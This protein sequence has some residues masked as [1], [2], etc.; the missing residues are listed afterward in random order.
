MLTGGLDGLYRA[1]LATPHEPIIRAEVWRGTD[2]IVDDLPIGNGEVTATL[3]S[4]VSRIAS[5]VTYEPFYDE[6]SPFT[7]TLRCFRGI[8]LGD[9]TPLEWPV[10]VGRL[11]D[12]QLDADGLVTFNA[13]DNAGAVLEN[14]FT[15]PEN[16]TVGAGVRDE[17]QRII[18][19]RF[20]GALFGPS[21]EYFQRVPALTWEHDPGQA[22][23]EMATA[24][25]SYWYALA[26][27]R[28][29]L[30]RFPWTIDSPAILTLSDG[31]GG[32]ILS[33]VPHKDRRGVYNQVTATGERVDGT[34]PV[35]YTASDDNPDSLTYVGG[36][37]GIRNKLLTLN[38]PDNV[39]VARGAAFDYLRRSTAHVESWTFVSVPD[40]ALELGDVLELHARGR[41][42]PRQVVA[43]ISMPLVIEG[44]MQVSC[45]AQVVGS[46]DV[47]A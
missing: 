31:D 4:R 26:T 38:T 1:A 39:D 41:R 6:V 27:G 28:F 15:V 11:T 40:A 9:G 10:F 5:L 45:R 47:T 13:E 44:T 23:D 43:S 35:F 7:D 21:D 42:A 14:G 33:A 36:P 34:A 8:R 16:S 29:V 37:F 20:P 25:G 30:R 2:R 3:T 32:T 46:L 22:L 17:I 24:V 12:S 19:D 18:S